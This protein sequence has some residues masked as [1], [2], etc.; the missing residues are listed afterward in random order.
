VDSVVK[1]QNLKKGWNCKNSYQ[2]TRRSKVEGRGYRAQKKTKADLAQVPTENVTLEISINAPMLSV[3][4][5]HYHLVNYTSIAESW[6]SKNYALEFAKCI[7]YA[8][9]KQ[10]LD[11]LS[12]S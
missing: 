12:K 7:K 1:S 3:Q 10:L 11:E 8:I 5:I 4:N 9:E 2:N 6:R